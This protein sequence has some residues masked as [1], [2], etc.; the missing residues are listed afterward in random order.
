MDPVEID[1]RTLQ[2]ISNQLVVPLEKLNPDTHLVN[3]L[4]A[5]SLDAVELIMEL[6]EEFEINIPDNEAQQ[7]QTVQQIMDGIKGH[8]S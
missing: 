6:E 3:D 7:Y 2:V 5:D 1:R 4:G 8:L